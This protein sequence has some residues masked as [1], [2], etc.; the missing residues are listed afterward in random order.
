MPAFGGLSAG[1]CAVENSKTLIWHKKIAIIWSIESSVGKHFVNIILYFMELARIDAYIEVCGY[2]LSITTQNHFMPMY[3]WTVFTIYCLQYITN[4][5][6][7]SPL[8]GSRVSTN[9]AAPVVSPLSALAAVSF[10][11]FPRRHNLSR[12]R[13]DCLWRLVSRT[14]GCH[15]ASS[16]DGGRARAAAAPATIDS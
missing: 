7:L 3:V 8:G 14:P 1:D 6:T 10:R 2:Q 16:S 5:E 15:R 11:R 9:F 12:S 4:A 13:H